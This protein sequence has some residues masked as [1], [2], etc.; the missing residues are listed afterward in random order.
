MFEVRLR[1]NILF[2]GTVGRVADEENEEDDVNSWL[3]G[4]LSMVWVGGRCTFG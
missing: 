3:V 1:V 2:R 4:F